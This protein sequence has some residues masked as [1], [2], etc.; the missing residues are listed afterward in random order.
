[1]TD[2]TQEA[3]YN[4]HTQINEFKV[5]RFMLKV[6][7]IWEFESDTNLRGYWA[8]N[9]QHLSQLQAIEIYTGVKR[10]WRF[11]I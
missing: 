3:K 1:M 5:N 6:G 10:W 4:P 2:N 8:K 9:G 7:F 11:W